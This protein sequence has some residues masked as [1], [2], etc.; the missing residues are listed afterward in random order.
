MCL[1]RSVAD[2]NGVKYSPTAA[3]PRQTGGP[4]ETLDT[5]PPAAGVTRSAGGGPPACEA[6]GI[7]AP[8]RGS[9]RGGAAGLA[10]RLGQPVPAAPCDCDSAETR[11]ALGRL[12]LGL[13][14][15]R[16]LYP[17]RP[18]ASPATDP[19]PGPEATPQD[20]AEGQ[21]EAGDGVGGAP[22]VPAAA[23]VTAPAGCPPGLDFCYEVNGIGYPVGQEV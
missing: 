5:G 7:R 10:R 3:S 13:L 12:A 14:S 9:E 15:A 21:C 11:A 2:E 1:R 18:S 16:T 4:Q 19:G 22:R 23:V 6:I 17:S 20:P 8:F